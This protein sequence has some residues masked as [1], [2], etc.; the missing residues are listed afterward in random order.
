MLLSIIEDIP[1][2][3]SLGR[4]ASVENSIIEV[5]AYSDNFVTGFS[6]IFNKNV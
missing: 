2:V 4:V 6:Y 1:Q 5:Y 3:L